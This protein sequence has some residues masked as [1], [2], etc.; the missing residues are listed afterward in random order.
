[1]YSKWQSACERAGI[2]Y[3]RPHQAGRHAFATEMIV[4]NRVPA[5]TTAKLGGWANTRMLDRY[6]HPEGL[7]DV[8]DAVFATPKPQERK[9]E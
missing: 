9:A 2:D 4:R 1:M 8:V 5:V 6:A 7:E 3:I